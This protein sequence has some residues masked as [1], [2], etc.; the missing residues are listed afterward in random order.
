MFCH[1]DY[2][3]N[4]EQLKS[5]KDIFIDTCKRKIVIL[6]FLFFFRQPRIL[7]LRL[8]G[9]LTCQFRGLSCISHLDFNLVKYRQEL[10]NA[11]LRECAIKM[12]QKN[13]NLYIFRRIS[14]P[15][16]PSLI[17]CW[18]QFSIEVPLLASTS[19]TLP[20]QC[21]H[22]RYIYTCTWMH[23]VI[24][25]RQHSIHNQCIK[26]TSEAEQTERAFCSSS[27]FLVNNVL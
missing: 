8:S 24:N 10:F 18:L 17:N 2:I 5:F 3:R 12:Q 1:L 26:K 20:A 27:L 11:Q 14:V 21:K 25:T 9:G 7:H 16:K 19:R 23:Y 6:K 13:A 4:S 15:V 22:G